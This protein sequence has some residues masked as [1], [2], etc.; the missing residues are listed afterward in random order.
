MAAKESRTFSTVLIY[1]F[2]KD[3]AFTAGKMYAKI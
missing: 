1:L 2:L 3:S